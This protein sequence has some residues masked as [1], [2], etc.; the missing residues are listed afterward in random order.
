MEKPVI[1]WNIVSGEWIYHMC[2]TEEFI[3]G[4]F[5]IKCTLSKMQ[6][7]PFL[8]LKLEGSFWYEWF[9]LK[10]DMQVWKKC[11]FPRKIVTFPTISYVFLYWKIQNFPPNGHISLEGASWFPH[12]FPPCMLDKLHENFYVIWWTLCIK[13]LHLCAF[14][15]PLCSLT[16]H[17]VSFLNLFFK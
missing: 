2:N 17:F 14:L 16:S 6:L 8:L 4:Q 13:I 12:F 10:D 5:H 1:T 7:S 11:I 3:F 15:T 9:Y